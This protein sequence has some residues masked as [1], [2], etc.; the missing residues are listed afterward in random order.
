[1]AFWK[2][3]IFNAMYQLL[4]VPTVPP[5]QSFAIVH[6]VDDSYSRNSYRRHD[7]HVCCSSDA[8]TLQ[9]GLGILSA[10]KAG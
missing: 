1:M 2:E 4:V 7:D 3:F 10:V 9:L 8:D 5:E 6:N